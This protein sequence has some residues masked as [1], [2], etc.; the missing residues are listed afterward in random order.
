MPKKSHI[1]EYAMDTMQNERADWVSALFRSQRNK[2]TES[3]NKECIV[4]RMKTCESFSIDCDP[5]WS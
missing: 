3:G 4:H 5:T 1:Y 2:M